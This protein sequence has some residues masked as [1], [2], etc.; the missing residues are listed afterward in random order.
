M[1]LVDNVSDVIT[2]L[3]QTADKIRQLTGTSDL[4]YPIDFAN[5]I[6]ELYDDKG[7]EIQRIV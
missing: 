3:T 2:A 7:V 6:Q 1:S 5:K 4:I